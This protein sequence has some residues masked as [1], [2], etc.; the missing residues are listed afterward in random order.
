MMNVANLSAKKIVVMTITALAAGVKSS[1]LRT[2][3]ILRTKE[4]QYQLSIR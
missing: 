1:M 4:A 2:F 3:L